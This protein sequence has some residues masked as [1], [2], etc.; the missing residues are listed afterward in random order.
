MIT[1]TAREII[2]NARYL[3]GIRNSD[4]TDFYSNC[5]LLNNLYSELYIDV[6]KN[7]DNYIAYEDV[8]NGTQL[9]NDCYQIMAVYKYFAP[10][11]LSEI[12]PMPRN[13]RLNGSYYRIENDIIYFGDSNSNYRIKYSTLPQTLTAPDKLQKVDIPADAVIGA[14]TEEGVYYKTNKNYFYNFIKEASE[15]TDTFIPNSTAHT[16]QGYTVEFDKEAKTVSVDSKVLLTDVEN[17]IFSYPYSFA[18]FS[19]GSIHIYTGLCNDTLWNYYCTQGKQTLGTIEAAY[20]NEETGKGVI[21]KKDNNFYYGSFV[22]DTVLTYPDNTFFSLIEYKMAAI[23]CSLNGQDAS[24]INNV[25]IPNAEIK[26]YQTIRKDSYRP[27]RM[28]NV[29]LT[30]RL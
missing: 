22:P 17:Y 11:N 4:I 30:P 3:A 27:F 12:E 1:K 2:K 25:L 5:L 16:F 9:P 14:M 6:I 20:T 29:I 26:F 23:L 24:Y 15:E 7:A 18:S 21:Y 19:D 10:D 13:Q 28:E 8:T